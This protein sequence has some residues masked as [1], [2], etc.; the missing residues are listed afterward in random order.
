MCEPLDSIYLACWINL[1]ITTEI[2]EKN[3]DTSGTETVD[4]R[5]YRD[6]DCSWL[7]Q[8]RSEEI[9]KLDHSHSQEKKK[10]CVR[11]G[12]PRDRG[13]NDLPKKEINLKL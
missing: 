6:L 5:L 4:S 8:V 3:L 2:E 11:E 1:Y 12:L 7:R 9:T 10:I 13:Q